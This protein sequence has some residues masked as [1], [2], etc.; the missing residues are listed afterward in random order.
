M[1]AVKSERERETKHRRNKGEWE[2]VSDAEM[3]ATKTA[4]TQRT[5]EKGGQSPHRGHTEGDSERCGG[6]VK[7]SRVREGGGTGGERERGKRKVTRGATP[8]VYTLYMQCNSLVH[9]CNGQ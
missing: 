7:G 8:L 9:G 2:K 6:V 4:E 3:A 1:R 5:V